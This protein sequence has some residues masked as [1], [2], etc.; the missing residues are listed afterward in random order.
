MRDVLYLHQYV[1]ITHTVDFVLTYCR[2]GTQR[3]WV[4]RRGK[5]YDQEA[6]WKGQEAGQETRDLSVFVVASGKFDE[7]HILGCQC[8][9]SRPGGLVPKS[10]SINPQRDKKRPVGDVVEGSYG[11]EETVRSITLCVP[12]ALAEVHKGALHVSVSYHCQSVAISLTSS[13]R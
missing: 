1:F 2:T 11:L 7:E 12:L 5:G 8:M 6:R 10:T 4:F 3:H 13:M 9:V